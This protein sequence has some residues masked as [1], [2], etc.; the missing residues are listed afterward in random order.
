[1]TSTDGAAQNKSHVSKSS[2]TVPNTK[3]YGNRIKCGIISSSYGY[4]GE[5]DLS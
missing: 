2:K 4:L 3:V 5:K 1:M